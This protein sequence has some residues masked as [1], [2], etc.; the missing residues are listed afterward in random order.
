[1][2]S[3]FFCGDAA[4]RPTRIGTDGKQI[5]KDH[6]VCDRSFAMNIGLKFYTPEEYFLKVRTEEFKLPLFNPKDV[7]VNVKYTNSSS[8]LIS[9]SK[10]VIFKIC[11]FYRLHINFVIL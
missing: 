10:E 7:M 4:G 9:S 6:S 2:Q 11:I 8:P 5:K 3:S 1:M